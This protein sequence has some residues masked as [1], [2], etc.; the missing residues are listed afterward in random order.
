M[1]SIQAPRF[2]PHGVTARQAAAVL[3]SPSEVVPG[4]ITRQETHTTES[5]GAVTGEVLHREQKVSFGLFFFN[6]EAEAS[7]A[8]QLS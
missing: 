5:H 3:Q 8:E 2:L 7:A 1:C 6:R 4:V